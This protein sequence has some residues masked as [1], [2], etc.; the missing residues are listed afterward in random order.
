MYDKIKLII[1]ALM[2]AR[3]TGKVYIEINFNTGG[4]TGIKQF[5]EFK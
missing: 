4:I 1:E 3:F 2:R 5:R